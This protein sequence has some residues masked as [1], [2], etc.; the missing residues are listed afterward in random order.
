MAGMGSV[1][2][3]KVSEH[4]QYLADQPDGFWQLYWE[5]TQYEQDTN[6]KSEYQKISDLMLI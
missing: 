4:H 1:I 5:R 3:D 2:V 6:I